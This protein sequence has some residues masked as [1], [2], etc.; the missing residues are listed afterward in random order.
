MHLDPI[1]LFES[2]LFTAGAA[3]FVLAILLALY[4]NRRRPEPPRYH[5]DR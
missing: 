1:R 5:S 3:F 2:V 4:V